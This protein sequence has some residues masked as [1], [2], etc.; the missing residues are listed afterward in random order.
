MAITCGFLLSAII[1]SDLSIPAI[2]HTKDIYYILGISV[3]VKLTSFHTFGMFNGMWRYTSLIDMG[4][5]FKANFI[6][7]MLLIAGIGYFLSL[8]H[9]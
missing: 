4:N 1:R 6:G 8:I 9:I 7:T 3:A 5:I 2:F